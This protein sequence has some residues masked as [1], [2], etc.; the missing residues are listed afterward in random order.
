[1]TQTTAQL[2]VKQSSLSLGPELRHIVGYS[3]LDI[4]FGL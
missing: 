2:Q 4:D 1:L 3:P